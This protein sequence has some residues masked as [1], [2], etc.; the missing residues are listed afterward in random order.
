MTLCLIETQLEIKVDTYVMEVVLERQF[1]I[2]FNSNI[3]KFK[4]NAYRYSM[5]MTI[6]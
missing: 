5:E 4:S 1:T 6:L 2:H 3:S